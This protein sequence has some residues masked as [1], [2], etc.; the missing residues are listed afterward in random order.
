MGEAITPVKNFKVENII[1]NCES[2]N[3]LEKEL[4][5]VLD[6]KRLNIIPVLKN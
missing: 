2:Y 6:K 5:K 4:R 1:F 3:N